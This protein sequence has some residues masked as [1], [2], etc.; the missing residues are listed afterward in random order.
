VTLSVTGS[1]LCQLECGFDRVKAGILSSKSIG[2]G[3]IVPGAAQGG[4]LIYEA[5]AKG[6]A[7]FCRTT[8]HPPAQQTCRRTLSSAIRGFI[9]LCDSRAAL[10]SEP[11]SSSNGMLL[12]PLAIPGSLLEASAVSTNLASCVNCHFLLPT[13]VHIGSR[14]GTCARR[15][16]SERHL[17]GL[18]FREDLFPLFSFYRGLSFASYQGRP[19]LIALISNPRCFFGWVPSELHMLCGFVLIHSL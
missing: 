10:L 12:K 5:A 4:A 3:I 15:R 2:I 14:R 9:F 17:V 8:T 1:P 11:F 6:L 13:Q 16:S 19:L 18:C 7:P